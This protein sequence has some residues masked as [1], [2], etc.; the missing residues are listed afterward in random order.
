[1]NAKLPPALSSL[2]IMMERG[3][4]P[5]CHY[6]NPDYGR[7]EPQWIDL[8]D[9]KKAVQF[10]QQRQLRLICLLGRHLPP[11]SHASVLRDSKAVKIVPLKFPKPGNA[12]VRV[13]EFA[14]AFAWEER[15]SVSLNDAIL[16]LERKDLG[17]LISVFKSLALKVKRLNVCLTDIGTFQEIDF[18][19]YREQLDL[20]AKI[21][22]G[23]RWP[24]AGT[25]C[26]LLTD[27]LM[28][29][30]MNNCDAGVKHVTVAPNGRFYLCPGFYHRDEADTLGGLESG[31]CPRNSRLWERDYSPICRECDA[32]QCRRCLLLN[33]QLTNEINIPSRQQCVTAHCEREASRKLLDELRR[34]RPLNPAVAEAQ[35]RRLDYLD[36]FELIQRRSRRNA[37]ETKNN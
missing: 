12:A 4:V 13:L 22:A 10:A 15:R 7:A 26:N 14:D 25:E 30:A 11:K 33:K 32:Y 2:L 34:R 35:I 18:A 36:P 16:R 29:R 6:S 17:Q 3:A 5:F 24:A 37:K 27:R 21:I 9:L 28:L 1:M 23:F 31:F 20:L 19:H 8:T